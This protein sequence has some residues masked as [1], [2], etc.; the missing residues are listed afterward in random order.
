MRSGG[1]ALAVSERSPSRERSNRVPSATRSRNRG[2]PFA[3]EHAHGVLVADAGPGDQ[4]VGQVL[5]G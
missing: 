5:L 1:G 3:H 4:G 2:R